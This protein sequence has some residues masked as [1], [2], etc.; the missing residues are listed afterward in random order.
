MSNISIANIVFTDTS[1]IEVWGGE[2]K[3]FYNIVTQ[4]G[5]YIA[6]FRTRQLAEQAERIIDVKGV[7]KEIL[8]NEAKKR[9]GAVYTRLDYFQNELENSNTKYKPHF[10]KGAMQIIN[11]YVKEQIEDLHNT[12]Q[13]YA[14]ASPSWIKKTQERPIKDF[15]REYE[16][17]I[18]SLNRLIEHHFYHTYDNKVKS[19][20]IQTPSI[21]EAR[22]NHAFKP[23]L[24]P[25]QFNLPCTLV[26]QLENLWR[27][28]RCNPLMED[29]YKKLEKKNHQKALNALLQLS[30]GTNE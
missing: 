29:L 18:K 17:S 10:T 9:F 12:M 15:T 21:V 30:E 8:I 23:F 20:L 7:S 25:I 13:G 14:E 28:K 11:A 4:K 16:I 3:N 6:T 27:I 22:K 5:E 2:D 26:L 24:I 19:L 1:I